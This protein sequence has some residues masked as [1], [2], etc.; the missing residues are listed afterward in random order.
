MGIALL[1]FGA[2]GLGA[3]LANVLTPSV[4][5]RWGRYAAANGALAAAAIIQLPGAGLRLPVMV[6]CGFLLGMAEAG[7]F[8]G[9]LLYL[10]YW[11]RQREQAQAV[12]LYLSGMPIASIL[13]S[14]VSGVILD[15]VHWLGLSSW[16]WLLIVEGIPA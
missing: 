7:F 10:T 4:V 1:F 8:P 11:F 12:G 2:A 9:V 16:R 14:P 6:V 3:F 15:R 13:G 5:R